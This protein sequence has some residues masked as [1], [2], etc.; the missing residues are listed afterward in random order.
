MTARGSR[1]WVARA[2]CHLK[3]HAAAIVLVV[4]FLIMSIG[5]PAAL[6]VLGPQ[7]IASPL[8]QPLTSTVS[9]QD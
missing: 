4:M 9:V 1:S 5:T 6:L 7:Q 3:Q 8:G 2:C